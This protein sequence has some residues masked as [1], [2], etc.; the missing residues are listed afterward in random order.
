MTIYFAS[1][2]INYTRW[3]Q[4]FGSTNEGWKTYMIVTLVCPAKQDTKPQLTWLL[5]VVCQASTHTAASNLHLPN[6]KTS[7]VHAHPE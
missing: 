4:L 5:Q 3:L 6:F 7:V 1:S 2:E